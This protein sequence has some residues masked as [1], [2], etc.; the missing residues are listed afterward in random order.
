MWALAVNSR[1]AWALSP[2]SAISTISRRAWPSALF[3]VGVCQLASLGRACAVPKS[4]PIWLSGP[5][6]SHRAGVAGGPSEA[7]GSQAASSIAAV[8]IQSFLGAVARAKIGGTDRR[9]EVQ[10]AFNLVK[11]RRTRRLTIRRGT[12]YS[13]SK[14]MSFPDTGYG[15][16]VGLQAVLHAVR[17]GQMACA[18]GHK[19]CSRL[20]H[21][22]HNPLG[23]IRIALGQ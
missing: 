7:P 14:P 1:A 16:P 23:P 22:F 17:P 21:P 8:A 15:E 11:K 6:T 9:G 19:N 20:F 13:C 10:E 4:Q 18:H 5:L 2:R 3:R 12:G